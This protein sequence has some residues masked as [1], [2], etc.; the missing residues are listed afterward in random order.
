MNTGVLVLLPP[1]LIFALALATR[2]V[3]IS[4]AV[5]IL[6]AAFIATDLSPLGGLYLAAKRLLE[7]T[8]IPDVIHQTG[9]YDKLYMFG[10]L[11]FLGIFI[12]C[13]THTGGLRIYTNRLLK[14]LKSPRQ[15]QLTSLMLSFLFFVD[16]YLNALMVGSIMRPITDHFKVPRAKLAY[17][18][19]AVS[20]PLAVLVPA[21]SWVGMIL[22]QL[23]ASGIHRAALPHSLMIIHPFRLYIGVIPFLF[24]PMLSIFTA[25]YITWNTISF[26]L[27]SRYE[28]QAKRDGNLFGGKAPLNARSTIDDTTGGSPLDIILPLLVFTILC[29][30]LIL[31]TGRW[32]ALGGTNTLADAFMSGNSVFALCVGAAG[33]LFVSALRIALNEKGAAQKLL[34]LSVQGFGLMKASLLILFLAWTLSTLLKDDLHTGLYISQLLSKS[35]GIALIPLVVFLA[36]AVTTATTG[37]SWGAIMILTPLALPLIITILGGAPL[38]SV[39]VYGVAPVV[40][41]LISGAIAGSHLSPITDAMVI[42][43]TSSQAYHLDHVQ[44]QASYS[45]IPLLG[46]IVAFLCA[47]LLHQSH[48]AIRIGCSLLLGILFCVGFVHIRARKWN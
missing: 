37:S 39:Y 10:F 32:I 6:A 36:T 11:I 43:S 13:M 23:E 19:N 35:V 22:T 18:L 46:A 42:A 47:G 41:A 30:T 14:R 25:W 29:S 16:D 38:A 45:L 1:L 21:S 34:K 9:S 2:N 27:M 12:E 3:L 33:A 48:L 4:L 40:G 17:L 26:G 20:A 7:Q 28:E 8:G 44:T 24:Y 5:G 15:A 31:Y